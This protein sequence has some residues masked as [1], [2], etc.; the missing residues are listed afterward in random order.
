MKKLAIPFAVGMVIGLGGST[1]AAMYLGGPEPTLTEE[2]ADAIG[3]VPADSSHADAPA[4][5]EHADSAAAHAAEVL[6]EQGHALTG[7]GANGHAEPSN[8]A[9]QPVGVTAIPAQGGAAGA[10]S[11]AELA[12]LF[13]TMQAREAARVLEHME[14]MEVQMI[15]GELGNREA[16]AILSNLTP[17][18]AAV[19]SRTILRGERSTP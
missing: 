13:A 5:G 8:A 12:K 10:M 4:T 15:L 7:T 19:I 11:S 14:D 9:A 17:E 2:L 16:A 6:A 1:A 18:R 3:E